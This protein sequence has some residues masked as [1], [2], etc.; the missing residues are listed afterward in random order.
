M[1][2]VITRNVTLFIYHT[3][4]PFAAPVSNITEI[5]CCKA[6]YVSSPL[7]HFIIPWPREPLGAGELSWLDNELCVADGIETAEFEGAISFLD[8]RSRCVHHQSDNLN[9]WRVMA[10]P[11]TFVSRCLMNLS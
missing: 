2:V 9:L 8:G 3:R 11:C 6:H 4:N 7:V 1:Q 10:C 5:S